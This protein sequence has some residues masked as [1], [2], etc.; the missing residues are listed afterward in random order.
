MHKHAR[1]HTQAEGPYKIFV[2]RM[3]RH[4]PIGISQ[5][6]NMWVPISVVFGL[7][8]PFTRSVE[9]IGSSPPDW[10][11]WSFSC[12]KSYQSSLSSLVLSKPINATNQCFTFSIMNT[13]KNNC[14]NS[15][16]TNSESVKVRGGLYRVLKSQVGTNLKPLKF[17][18]H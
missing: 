1:R 5:V 15:S 7:C 14:Q 13:A 10:E 11:Q 6:L 4:L 18:Q 3:Q 8:G 12:T 16:L 2:L 17:K 9:Q